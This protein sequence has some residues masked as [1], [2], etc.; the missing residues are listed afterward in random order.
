MRRKPHQ[1]NY[2]ADFHERLLAER[3]QIIF[4]RE[5]GLELLA[6]WETL[7]LDDQATLLHE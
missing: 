7:A 2:S 1:I 5:G 3:S 6:M 4:G